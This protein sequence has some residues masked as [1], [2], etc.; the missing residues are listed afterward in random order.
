MVGFGL[1]PSN[2]KESTGDTLGGIGSGI[3]IKPGTWKASGN[4][5]FTGTFV[6]VPDRGYNVYVPLFQKT[7]L[8]SC[9]YNRKGAI[10]YQARQHEIDFVLSPYY[11]STNLDFSAAQKTLTFQYQKTVL[12]FGRDGQKT[13][14]LNPTEVK[15]ANGGDPEMPVVSKKLLH[16]TVDTE[17]IVFNGDGT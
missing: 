2:F 5:T 11:G 15:E 9:E 8:Y 3:D 13:S 17:G 4:G 10:D 14:G 7:Y 6:V 12:K 16:L 1:I